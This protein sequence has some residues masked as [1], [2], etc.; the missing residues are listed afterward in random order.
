MK[1][2]KMSEEETNFLKKIKALK[3][4]KDKLKNINIGNPRKMA[5]HISKM[6]RIEAE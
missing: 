1:T 3:E 4:N 5:A 6:G 2:N